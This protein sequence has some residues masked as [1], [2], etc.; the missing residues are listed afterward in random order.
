MK[1]DK[2]SGC[3]F[4]NYDD[5]KRILA[6][7]YNNNME[8]AERKL[9]VY[10]SDSKWDFPGCLFMALIG[11]PPKGYAVYLPHLCKLIFIDFLGTPYPYNDVKL[12]VDYY[13][14]TEIESI[15]KEML[16]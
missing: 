16:V 2:D 7:K 1:W 9:L 3:R 13:K 5:I 6:K 12:S 4:F 8:E 15:P 14:E 11:S 10:R